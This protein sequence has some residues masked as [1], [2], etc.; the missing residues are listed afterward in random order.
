MP[1]N[2]WKIVDKVIDESDIL[3][4]VMDSRMVAESRNHEIETK[5]AAAHKPLIYVINKADLVE[6]ET[7]EKWKKTLKPSVFISATMHLGGSYLREEILKRAPAGQFKVGVL[8]YPN[9]G[10]SSV[11]NMLKGRGAAKTSPTSGYTKGVQKVK[12]SERMY[13]LDTPGVFPYMEKDEAKHTMM[14]AR[15]FAD[16]KD[17]IGSC[18]KFIETFHS[19]VE[20]FYGV[21]HDDDPEV[22]LERI[23]VKLKK[24]RKGG[25]P[26]LDATAR[27]VIRAWQTGKIRK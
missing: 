6:K 2:F 5:V 26:D 15:T 24:L 21:R 22:V 12:I 3:L 18:M 9:T 4:L 10:K 14:S 11:I 20:E 25:E 8:G 1:K 13:V 23:A 16:V 7:M 17:P 27:M 19:Q